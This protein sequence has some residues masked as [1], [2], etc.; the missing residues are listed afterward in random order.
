MT[1]VYTPVSLNLGPDR[2]ILVRWQPPQ[3]KHFQY[4]SPKLPNCLTFRWI[5]VTYSLIKNYTRVYTV[6]RDSK[7]VICHKPCRVSSII[8]HIKDEMD[9]KLH[10]SF[11]CLALMP[12][13]WNFFIYSADSFTNEK[14]LAILYSCFCCQCTLHGKFPWNL[15]TIFAPWGSMHLSELG[16]IIEW[17]WFRSSMSRRWLSL[18]YTAHSKGLS[19]AIMERGLM[20]TFPLSN[21]LS[22]CYAWIPSNLDDLMWEVLHEN[23]FCWI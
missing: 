22:S 3:D 12:R 1:I 21:S 17:N 18:L 6:Q 5:A 8:L 15:I 13:S 16:S 10:V 4:W 11:W 9:S 7:V 2:N 23:W 19:E 14:H 20:V